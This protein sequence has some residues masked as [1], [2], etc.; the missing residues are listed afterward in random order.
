MLDTESAWT[1]ILQS[2]FNHWLNLKVF[3]TN[4]NRSKY[5][6]SS[7]Y[8]LYTVLNI[9]HTFVHFILPTRNTQVLEIV[10]QEYYIIPTLQLRKVWSSVKLSR[11]R[12]LNQLMAELEFKSK[13]YDCQAP[14]LKHYTSHYLSW[15]V[16]VIKTNMITANGVASIYLW[17]LPAL[18]R[19][20]QRRKQQ[21]EAKFISYLFLHPAD[22]Y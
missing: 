19:G 22:N 15:E 7:Y 13:W 4:N 11:P 10:L 21:T 12:L 5:S 3:S 17:Q 2:C 9:L 6:N 18:G 8:V 16:T 1:K 20:R 14:A